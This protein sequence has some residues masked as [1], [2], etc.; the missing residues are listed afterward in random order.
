MYI[1]IYIHT[2]KCVH[3]CIWRKYIHVYKCMYTCRHATHNVTGDDFATLFNT[4]CNTL[5]HCAT[6]GLFQQPSKWHY[7]NFCWIHI[8]CIPT[9]I[10]KTYYNYSHISQISITRIPKY[11]CWIHVICIP[12]YVHIYLCTYMQICMHIHMY[13]HKCMYM[14]IFMS[15]HIYI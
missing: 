5:P 2:S 6:H 14:N 9:H 1:Y 3:V 4:H 7:F 12:K 11:Q 13:I 8:L 15:V 10:L